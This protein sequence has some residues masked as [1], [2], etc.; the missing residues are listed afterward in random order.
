M[1]IL[2]ILSGAALVIA[3]TVVLVYYFSPKRKDHVEAAKYEMLNDYEQ[4][5]ADDE[6]ESDSHKE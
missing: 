6:P 3:F 1:A 4:P 2:Y 5:I